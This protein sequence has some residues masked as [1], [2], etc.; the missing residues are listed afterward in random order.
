MSRPRR[1]FPPELLARL[2]GMPVTAALDLL[3]LYWKHDP[4]FKPI[5]NSATVRLNV[6]LGGGGVE[7]LATGPKWYD[8]RAE[9]GG[10]GAIDLAMH[11]LHLDF[12]A[13][14][15]RLQAAA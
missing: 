11:L 13:A 12:V 9:R 14:V 5:K 6:G 4:D 10:G 8:T 7:L 2:Q 3:G 1:A 15:K